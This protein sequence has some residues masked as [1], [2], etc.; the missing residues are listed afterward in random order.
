MNETRFCL[1]GR[2]SCNVSEFTTTETELNA[3]ANPA[4]SGCRLNHRY[5]NTQAATGIHNTL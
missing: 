5:A 2:K 4:N 3:I 1:R